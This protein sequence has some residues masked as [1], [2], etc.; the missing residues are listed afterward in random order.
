MKMRNSLIIL[1]LTITL[2]SCWRSNPIPPPPPPEDC[3]G[4]SINNI[5]IYT[6]GFSPEKYDSV[7]IRVFNL[8]SNKPVDSCYASLDKVLDRA[9][10][11][12]RI[13]RSLK[14]PNRFNTHQTLEL[15]F[16]STH[17]YKLSNFKTGWIARYC[18]EFC[19][20]DCQCESYEINGVKDSSGSNISIK[21]PDY[22]YPWEKK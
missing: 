16:D 5:G 18:H 20:Y 7:F 13:D 2:V 19:G 21:N 4:I 9:F 3:L 14:I 12:D 11:K 6:H 8:E 1:I 17:I 15:H 22:A 10:N